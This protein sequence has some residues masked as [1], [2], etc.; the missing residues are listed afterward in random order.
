MTLK[1]GKIP[2]ADC[3]CFIG[4]CRSV[5]GFHGC[6]RVSSRSLGFRVLGCPAS[7][8]PQNLARCLVNG[9]TLNFLALYQL[10]LRKFELFGVRLLK[11]R[12]QCLGTVSGLWF[13]RSPPALS[14]A[15]SGLRGL[16]W[17]KF[18]VQGL[19]FRVSGFRD[20]FRTCGSVWSSEGITRFGG[21]LSFSK[22]SGGL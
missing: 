7:T 22:L 9:G 8:K 18:R 1:A 3:N 20:G 15:C 21:C 14:S 12:G 17:F 10:Y 2:K 4:F 13:S 19:G 11:K 16:G 6:R 5:Q